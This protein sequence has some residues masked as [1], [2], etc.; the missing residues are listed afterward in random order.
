MSKFK[1]LNDCRGEYEDEIVDQIFTT[2]GIKD[3]DKFMNPTE[4][5]LIPCDKL[6]NIDKAYQIL[7]QT[8]DK[9]GIIGCLWDVDQDGV[10]SGAIL[11]R[12][13]R[14]DLGTCVTS[15]IN[16]GKAHGVI[17]DEPYFNEVTGVEPSVDLLII[18]DS[19][20]E[21]TDE[22]SQ[23]SVPMIVLDH[24][25][26][27]PAVDYNKYITLVTSQT[28]YPNHQL[29]G[30]GVTW[31]FC[32]YIDEQND[33]HYADKYLDLCASG[34]IADVMDMTVPE[35]RYLVR[36][37]LANLN[38]LAMKKMVGSYTFNST[39]VSFSIAPLVNAANRMNCNEAI[40]NAFMSDDNKYVLSQMRIVKKCK[41]EQ[42]AKV[43]EQIQICESDANIDYNKHVLM[44]KLS[45]IGGLSGLIAQKLASKHNRPVFVVSYNEHENDWEGSCR[46]PW[47]IDFAKMVNDTELARGVGHPQAFGFFIDE[48]NID[49]FIDTLDQQLAHITL[50]ESVFVDAQL[51]PDDL[52]FELANKI[53]SM[54]F[55]SGQGW[56]PVKFLIDGITNYDVTSMKDGKH[57]KLVT[58]NVDYIKWNSPYNQDDFEDASLLDEPITCV[59]ELGISAFGGWK[60]QLI[61]DEI[62]IGD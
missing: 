52:T 15:F 45:G 24:H 47:N 61:C 51:N 42:D 6:P 31:K 34:L 9:G 14:D 59:G 38:N 8:I 13:L 53:E 7:V 48:S 58:D 55:I 35:N 33:Y 39:A 46:C 16:H 12:Y 11:T 36:M 18:V 32:K 54:N 40:M 37:G 49:K 21:T 60:L 44:Y 23:V 19:L 57:L 22:Y 4:Y 3:P 62:E 2:R 56:K 50:D 41:K 30:A 25:N 17:R 26:V 29:S 27:N 20:N 43:D 10:A 5:D 28:S 1:V